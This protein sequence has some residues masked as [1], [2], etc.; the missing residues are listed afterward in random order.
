MDSQ[1][2]PMTL[3]EIIEKTFTLIGKT[4]VRN[5]IV[6][7]IFLVVPVILLTV[8]ADIFYS[9]IANT[10]FSSGWFI[11]HPGFD[12]VTPFLGV[13]VIFLVA[14]LVLSLGI[15]LAELT[16]SY[17]VGKELMGEPVT[18]RDAIEETF[19]VK[20]LYGIEQALLKILIIGGGIAILAFFLSTLAV[21]IDNVIV[22]GFFIAIFAIVAIPAIVFV[23]FRWYFS[24]TAVAIETLGPVDSLR[25]SWFLVGDN[26]WRT[27]GI[28]LLFSVLYQFVVSIISLPLTFGSMFNFYRD[29]FAALAKTGGNLDQQGL[30]QI[31]RS[32]G[33]TIGIGTG[34]TTLLSLL[35]TP[36]F[37]VVMYFDLR[38]RKNDLPNIP[39]SPQ[40][41]AAPQPPEIIKPTPGSGPF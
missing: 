9:S 41:D 11:E 18:F 2:L 8:A 35:I 25:Q 1:I 30:Q 20:W 29:F 6:A 16:I 4:V 27:F 12:A 7:A 28:L 22:L 38:A 39:G 17:I 10:S 32:L 15:L 5:L 40:A 26:W 14:I 23:A 36:V 34:I 13:V 37:T 19:N 3:G 31:Q 24:L 21:V 33:P